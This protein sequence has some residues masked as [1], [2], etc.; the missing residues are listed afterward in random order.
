[1]GATA[2]SAAVVPNSVISVEWSTNMTERN[3]AVTC[4]MRDCCWLKSNS[5]G[6]RLLLMGWHSFLSVTVVLLGTAVAFL[7][8]ASPDAYDWLLKP[9]TCS[10]AHSN[11]S[12]N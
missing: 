12:H 4:G 10:F 5:R 11:V 9:I 8:W 3:A 7:A 2:W 6:S 1:M